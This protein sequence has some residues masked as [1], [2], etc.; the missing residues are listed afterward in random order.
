MPKAKK[1]AKKASKAKAKMAPRKAYDLAY[2]LAY[3]SDYE[4]EYDSEEEDD[5]E[6]MNMFVRRLL[7]CT[8]D[9]NKFHRIFEQVQDRFDPKQLGFYAGK[10]LNERDFKRLILCVQSIS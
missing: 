9:K 4:F 1:V 5:S 2:D 3:D 8:G 6:E 7:D 10:T